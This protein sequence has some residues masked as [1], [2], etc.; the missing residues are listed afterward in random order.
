MGRG[1]RFP[2]RPSL[3]LSFILLSFL[4]L[5]DMVLPLGV[6][7]RSTWTLHDYYIEYH[8]HNGP[9]TPKLPFPDLHVPVYSGNGHTQAGIPKQTDLQV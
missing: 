8:K 4:F 3:L 1:M 6:P 9:M 5:C 2:L 7:C